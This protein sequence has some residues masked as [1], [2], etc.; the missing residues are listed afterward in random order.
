MTSQQPNSD[1]T[2][3]RMRGNV[4]MVSN[5]VVMMTVLCDIFMFATYSVHVFKVH[6]GN[7]CDID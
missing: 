6:M 4:E 2:A 1:G 5:S 7:I 3:K